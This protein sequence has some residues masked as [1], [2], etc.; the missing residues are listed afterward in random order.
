MTELKREMNL[1]E[2]TKD[3][4]FDIAKEMKP[5]LTTQEYEEMWRRF[6]CAKSKKQLQ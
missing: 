2:F 1:N 3:E 5:G 6:E 4:W